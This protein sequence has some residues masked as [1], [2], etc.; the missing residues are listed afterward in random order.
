MATK[1]GVAES[2]RFL[3]GHAGWFARLG[4]P[5]VYDPD[6]LISRIGSTLV[7]STANVAGFHV[8]TFNQLKLTEDWRQSH[9]GR[10]AAQ[11]AS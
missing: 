11:Q 2:S 10:F 4:T 5:G 9:V 3:T 8:F 1:I 6:R 7:S